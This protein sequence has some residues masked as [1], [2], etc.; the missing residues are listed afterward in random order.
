MDLRAARAHYESLTDDDLRV[1]HAAG[2]DAFASQQAWD[3]LDSVFRERFGPDTESRSAVATAAQPAPSPGPVGLG[4]WL[5]LVGLGL[6]AG[7]LRLLIGVVVIFPLVDQALDAGQGRLAA[8]VAYELA[9]TIVF[10]VAAIVLLV[11]FFKRSR[12]FPKGFIAVGI[13]NL[14]FVL[15]DLWLASGV[16]VEINGGDP[17]AWREVGRATF[18]VAIWVPYMLMSKRVANT[19]V[20]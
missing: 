8:V 1:Q 12:F 15:G 9:G 6:V 17:A 4:G 16:N 14:I 7:A 5:I 13:A 20:M 2:P 10:A 18:S 19:F 3:V 11:L